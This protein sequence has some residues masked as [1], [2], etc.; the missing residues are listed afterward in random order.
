M[1]GESVLHYHMYIVPNKNVV[2]GAVYF[3]YG[4]YFSRM[5]DGGGSSM[6]TGKV[7]R[8]IRDSDSSSE[9]SSFRE[10]GFPTLYF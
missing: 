3:S 9:S 8:N 10:D 5:E 7:N 2:N 6:T 1:M 4:S